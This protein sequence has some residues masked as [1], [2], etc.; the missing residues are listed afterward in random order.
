[1]PTILATDVGLSLKDRQ[2]REDFENRLSNDPGIRKELV[3]LRKIAVA[4]S[5][6]I[7]VAGFL[8]WVL[9]VGC[10][11]AP[12]IQA[13]PMSRW[14]AVIVALAGLIGLRYLVSRYYTIAP[15]VS[16]K[17]LS[18]GIASVGGHA[19]RLDVYLTA[20]ALLLMPYLIVPASKNEFLTRIV[21][22]LGGVVMVAFASNTSRVKGSI[23]RFLGVA[24]MLALSFEISIVARALT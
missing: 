17:T 1:M 4:N 16:K 20:S 12:F 15:L 23:W 5:R 8:L 24:A 11:M 13:I 10:L 7:A 19:G 21:C 9:S 6:Q 22:G 18:V 14:V 3:A 2:I